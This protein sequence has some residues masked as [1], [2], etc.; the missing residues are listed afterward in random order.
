LHIFLATDI[1][2][3]N[4]TELQSA[5]ARLTETGFVDE[6][7]F[8]NTTYDYGGWEVTRIMINN[9][10]SE[11]RLYVVYTYEWAN[12]VVFAIFRTVDNQLTDTS[13]GYPS[14]S[15]S[16]GQTSGTPSSDHTYELVYS[17]TK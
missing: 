3:N 7:V 5:D 16:T 8:D 4:L 14:F 9:T 2:A 11:S 10:S 13:I 6:F 12:G 15:T 17:W 1:F